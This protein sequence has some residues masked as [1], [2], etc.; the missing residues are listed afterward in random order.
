[1]ISLDGK[2]IASLPNG[3]YTVEVE[4]KGKTRQFMC[5]IGGRVRRNHIIITDGDNVKIE[6][7]ASDPKQGKIVYRYR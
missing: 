5:Y 6:V 2:I 4:H 7:S 3:K 1:M